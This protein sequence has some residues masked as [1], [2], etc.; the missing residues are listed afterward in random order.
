MGQLTHAGKRYALYLAVLPFYRQECMTVLRDRLGVSLSAFAGRRHLDPSIRTGIDPSLYVPVTNVSVGG[1]VLLQLGHWRE[2]AR[3]QTTILDL[4]PRSVSA[5]ILLLGRRLTRKR[6]LLWGHLN[7][8]A[9]A[10]S[11]TVKL[12]DYM[13]GLADGTVLYG[14]DSV[15]RARSTH[16]DL[17]VWVAPNSLYRAGD[18][19]P[20]TLSSA[21]T[22][23]LYVGRLVA[24]KK[25][26]LLVRALAEPEMRKRGVCADIVGEGDEKETL[27]ALARQLGVADRTRFL[28]SK[29]GVAQ[30][31]P[32][33]EHAVCALSTGY[34]G[35]NLTQS[36]GFGVPIV[37]ADDEPHAPEI[38]LVKLGGV[39]FFTAN[40]SSSLAKVV[41][42]VIDE[43][44]SQDRKAL[45]DR[46]RTS[47]SAEAMAD[48]LA[49]A[50][51]NDPQDLGS[52]GWPLQ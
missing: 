32:L 14:Y 21:S 1:R 27:I 6:T 39:Q 34:A 42:R 41:A 19:K 9:G 36:L 30:L 16:P 48:G 7:P 45:S 33:Y 25:V 47:Y 18:M 40:D 8:R 20:A 5:W 13:R 26:E 49:K 17:P 10:Q 12:R 24:S 51:R 35:L 4:N 11:R 38:E 2:A 22:R 15:V 52:N 3:A 37:V 44:G 29:I 28:G 23:V 31:F 50:F 46:V 43:Q